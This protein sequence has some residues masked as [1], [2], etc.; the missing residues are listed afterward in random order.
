MLVL[1]LGVKK[2]YLTL[3]NTSEILLLL[4]LHYQTRRRELRLS[5]RNKDAGSDSKDGSQVAGA[6]RLINNPGK[7]KKC[8]RTR[9]RSGNE[10]TAAAAVGMEPAEMEQKKENKE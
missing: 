8:L 6:P 1:Q 4:I 9:S 10:P 2:Q 3:I 7:M 5:V